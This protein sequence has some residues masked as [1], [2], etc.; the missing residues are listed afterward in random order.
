MCPHGGTSFLFTDYIQNILHK[1]VVKLIE[2]NGA[3]G[4]IKY[5][6]IRPAALRKFNEFFKEENFEQIKTLCICRFFVSIFVLS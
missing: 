1:A 6:V 5:G 2:A 3:D 4:F